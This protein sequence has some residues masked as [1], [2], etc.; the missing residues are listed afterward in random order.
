MKYSTK[1]KKVFLFELKDKRKAT[2]DGK[3][4]NNG[5]FERLDQSGKP[6]MDLPPKGR[7]R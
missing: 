7:E 3:R 6:Y 1:R 5:Q 4:R 2:G